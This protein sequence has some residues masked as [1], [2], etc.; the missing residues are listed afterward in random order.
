LSLVVK[1]LFDTDAREPS[2]AAIPNDYPL[3]GRSI[4]GEL[5]YR[6]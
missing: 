3:E 2:S 1:N 5:Q 6:F 4:W